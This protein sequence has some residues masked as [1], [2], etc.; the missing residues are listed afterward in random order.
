MA[1]RYTNMGIGHQVA[2]VQSSSLTMRQTD[3][4]EQI[5]DEEHTARQ[6]PHNED[7]NTQDSDSDSESDLDPDD[8]LGRGEKEDSSSEEEYDDIDGDGGDDE[9]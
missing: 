8:D 2:G 1:L 3:E 5:D 6:P 7:H 9:N 4:N